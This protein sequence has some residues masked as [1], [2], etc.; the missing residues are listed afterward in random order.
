MIKRLALSFVSNSSKGKSVKV[1]IFTDRGAFSAI[2]PVGTSTGSYEAKVLSE[3]ET[4]KAFEKFKGK[5]VGMA[6][7]DVDSII[8]MVG[9]GS[10][11]SGFST[12][13]SI[14]S[15]RA[16]TSNE[17]YRFFGKS[18]SFP[19]PLSN[20]IGGGSHGGRISEQELLVLPI[21]AKTMKE[22]IDTNV[23]VW[24]EAGKQLRKHVT[25]RNRESAWM[26]KL[27]DIK[28]L[29]IL[30]KIAEDHGARV[31]I[32]FAAN[33]FY[34]GNYNYKNIKRSL[35][36]GEQLDFV[37]ELIKTYRLAYVEDPFQENDFTSFA[38][39]T[40]KA[41][42]LVVGDDLFVTNAQRLGEGINACAGNAIIIK[43]NQAG[44]IAR[45]METVSL[46]NKCKYIPVVSH[47][48]GETNDSFISDLA[49]GT[50][51]PI[52]KIGAKGK[53]EWKHKRLLELWNRIPKS[54]MSKLNF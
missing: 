37:L 35:S 12:A 5:F 9:I 46:A 52:I 21:G 33:G 47:R 31:G 13:L 15:V 36:R 4:R 18:F 42:C 30:S 45:T 24:K 48:S 50:G 54:K 26:C 2:A 14:A 49:V 6:E 28:S 7:R 25:G 43:P 20:I 16:M 10:M 11:G 51:S 1:S 27:N 34:N 41:G 44:T 23:S 38:D 32:D 19:Y 53:D 8:E 22:A 17:P 39:L 29:D 40:K 3:S